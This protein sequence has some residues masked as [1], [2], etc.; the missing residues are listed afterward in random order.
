[1]QRRNVLSRP[2]V[3]GREIYMQKLIEEAFSFYTSPPQLKSHVPT[4]L[5]NEKEQ[6]GHTSQVISQESVGFHTSVEGKSV[7]HKLY[8]VFRATSS[9]WRRI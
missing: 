6:L 9:H 5:K 4:Y 8:V 2:E 7:T 1:M 3:L